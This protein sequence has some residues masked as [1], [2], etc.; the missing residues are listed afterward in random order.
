MNG[1]S[2][3]KLWQQSK[4]KLE[5]LCNDD[6]RNIIYLEGRLLLAFV[7][8]IHWQEIFLN[9]DKIIANDKVQLLNDYLERLINQEP[10]Y[11]IIGCK[12]FYGREFKFSNNILEPRDDTIALIELVRPILVKQ[13]H[14]T[15]L[16][17]GCGS[18]IITVTLL[19]EFPHLEMT[20][21]DISAEALKITLDNAITH[22]VNDRL[23]LINSDLFN[24]LTGKFNLIISNPPYLSQDDMNNLDNKVKNFDPHIA[25]F[26]GEDGLKFYK[27]IAKQAKDFLANNGYIAVEIGKGQATDI[28]KIFTNENFNFLQYNKDLA[29]ITRAL[30]FQND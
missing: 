15:A 11:R 30:L 18:G 4:L 7:C 2:L 26:G 5:I 20:A 12:D 27:N 6:N 21:V 22:Q 29:G 9:P 8:K 13:N 17:I 16:D 25:L 23:T 28:I 19:A 14:L 24:N 3:S 10:I 1:I